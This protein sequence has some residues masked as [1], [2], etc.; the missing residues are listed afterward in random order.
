MELNRLEESVERGHRTAVELVH[1]QHLSVENVVGLHH[2][3]PA[4]LLFVEVHVGH[5]DEVD[6]GIEHGS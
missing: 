4:L 2:G 5:A 6:V 3:E 1:E